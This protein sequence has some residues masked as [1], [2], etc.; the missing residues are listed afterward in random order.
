MKICLLSYNHEPYIGGIETYS[1]NLYDFLKINSCHV[2]LISG[3]ITKFKTI[4]ILEVI[5]RFYFEN[6]IRSYDIVHITN[7]NLWP[8]LLVNY[9]KKGKTKFVI[10]LHGLEIVY[11][12][13]NKLASKLYEFLIP[14]GLINRKDNIHFICNSHQTLELA[15]EKINY[16]KLTYIPMGIAKVNKLDHKKK[17]K[18]NEIFFF[19]R[20]VKRKGLSWFCSNVL[21]NLKNTK[22]FYAGPIIDRDEFDI[23]N[24]FSE[25]EYLGIISEKEKAKRIQ[26]S[27][28]TIIP[29]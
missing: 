16:K 17:I 21:V 26:A 12:N 18:Q 10:N 28:F 9:F 27:F 7:L 24:S 1:K 6:L 20:I 15:K 3:K 22:L 14:Y 5:I 19:G 23:I 8:V 4:R 13:R 29:N 11:G 25:T 2:K